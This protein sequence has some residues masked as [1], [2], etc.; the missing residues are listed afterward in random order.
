MDEL[1]ARAFSYIQMEEMAKYRDGVRVEHQVATRGRDTQ[2]LKYQVF[3]PLTTNKAKVTIGG[4]QVQILPLPQK[5]RLHNRGMQ[6]MSDKIEE[7]VQADHLRNFVQRVT[8]QG[9]LDRKLETSRRRS[10]T[11]PKRE[12][13]QIPDQQAEGTSR[14]KGV[15]NTIA[16]KFA[17]GGPTSSARKRYLRTINIIHLG[18]D[19]ARR[20]L[21]P[22]TFTD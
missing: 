11:T 22:I 21:P 1:R 19:K 13:P 5:L 6:I 15:I 2:R 20:K 14:L 18:T 16:G 10:D 9:H 12:E 3:T 7:L 8:K 17:R 4:Q